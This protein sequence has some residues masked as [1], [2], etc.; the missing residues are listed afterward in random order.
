MKKRNN[1]SILNYWWAANYGANL[2]AYALNKLIPN[3]LLVDNT[4]FKQD[5]VENKY[6][7]HKNFAK[8][9]LKTIN[10]SSILQ[11]TK[12]CVYIT[13][14]DQVF[15]PYLNQNISSDYF[16]DF[17]NYHSK[18]IA[19]S[20]SFGVDKERFIK[21]NS[22]ETVL[23]MKNSL[24]SFDF[25]SVREKSG[26]EICRDILGIEA[27]W[28]ID[29]VFILEK[30]NYDKLT[31]NSTVDCSDKTVSYMMN[32]NIDN[33]N[34]EQT[35]ELFASKYSVENWLNAIK[36][37]KL[38]ITNSF[39]GVC[40]AIIFNKPFIC[41]VNSET[42]GARYNSL[43]EMLGIEN[44]CINSID[45]IYERDCVFKVDWNRVNRRIDEERQRGL[46]FLKKALNAPWGKFEE[47]QAVRTKYLE[48]RV[49]EL[50]CQANLKYQIKKELW[51]LWLVIFHKYLPEPVKNLIRKLRGKK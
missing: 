49:S 16:L 51:N 5:L 13:G 42:G 25:I 8:K 23:Q 33:F 19:F 36:T 40:F 15:R 2:T 20:A 37:C 22:E 12:A 24:K 44:Q 50:E 10:K 18:K 34:G 1:I 45:E 48:D 46:E 41:I 6:L 47:K 11:N 21:E 38:F 31:N 4:D 43:F 9:Y 14:S 3:S 27:E 30:S 7:F 32:S 28:I 29:P 26:I 39:H 17:A 35:T